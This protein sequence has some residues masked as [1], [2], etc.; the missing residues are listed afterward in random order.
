MIWPS[1]F[2][3]SFSGGDDSM[4]NRI[5]SETKHKTWAP[6][7]RLLIKNFFDHNVGKNAAALAYYLLFALFPLLIFLSNLLGLLN[8]NVA[9]ITDSL[10]QFM[11]R[12][13]LGIIESYLDY[14]SHTSSH[15]LLL[16][17]LVFSIWFPMR[18]V[19]GLMDAVRQAYHLGKP[20]HPISYSLRQLAYTVLF[21]LV[22]GMTLLLSTLGKRVLGYTNSLLPEGTLRFSGIFLGI[23]Q[24]LRFIPVGLLMFAALGI[25]YAASL[26]E[27]QPEGALRPGI[28]FAMIAWMFVSVAF[29]FYVE[30]FSH[31]SLIYGT[32]GAV[33]VMLIWLYMTSFILIMGA[34]LNG[35]LA[36]IRAEQ[37]RIDAESVEKSMTGIIIQ[38]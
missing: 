15:T 18:A 31:Y 26:D 8:L 24:Y 1:I 3:R 19:K 13:V 29:S 38:D 20:K 4:K 35:V 17:T 30:N 6:A 22:M 28:I 27:Q 10:A 12:D 36:E 2:R 14:V 16:F 21:L 9:A 11:P 7:L 32:L 5:P 23:W 25:L 33:M 34:E 37:V